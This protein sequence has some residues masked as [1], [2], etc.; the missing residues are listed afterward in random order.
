MDWD[1]AEEHFGMAK[2]S[3]RPFD[4]QIIKK[5]SMQAAAEDVPKWSLDFVYIDA[6]HDFNHVMQDI[7]IWSDRV[8]PG[9]IVSGHDYNIKSVKTAVDAYVKIHG[10]EL[11]VTEKGG[12]YPDSSPSWFFAK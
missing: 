4:A 9:G 12:G 6:N 2:K 10:C 8:R 7:I 5:T 1:D 11:F 3:L